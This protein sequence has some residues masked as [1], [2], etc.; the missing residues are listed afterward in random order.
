MAAQRPFSQL[1]L[2][3]WHHGRKFRTQTVLNTVT[4]LLSVGS[5][6]AFVGITKTAIDVATHKNDTFTLTQ[7][8]V[9]MLCVMLFQ[10]LGSGFARCARTESHATS[11]VPQVVESQLDE[12]S[13][14]SQW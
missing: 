8:I 6:L 5:G 12:H 13:S 9:M 14:L 10:P 7:V 1:F 2:W 11:H 4:G 3:L